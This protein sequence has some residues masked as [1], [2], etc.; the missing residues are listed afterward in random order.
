MLCSKLAGPVARRLVARTVAPARTFGQQQQSV[1]HVASRALVTGPSVLTPNAPARLYSTHGKNWL[2]LRARGLCS[3][4]DWDTDLAELT[5]YFS[6]TDG[7]VDRLLRYDTHTGICNAV[8]HDFIAD[9][10]EPLRVYLKLTKAELK[11]IMLSHPT[12]LHYNHDNMVKEKL[13]PLQQYFA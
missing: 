10:L 11:K 6:L 13:E 5:Q 3:S 2:C 7:E 8:Y 1:G 9:R 12:M 4:V